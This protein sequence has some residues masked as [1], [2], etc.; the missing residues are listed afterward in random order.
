M[1][2]YKKKLYLVYLF[3]NTQLMI[4][5]SR[6]MAQLQYIYLKKDIKILSTGHYQLLHLKYPMVGRIESLFDQVIG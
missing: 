6:M 3:L 1:S 4:H 2:N 5:T